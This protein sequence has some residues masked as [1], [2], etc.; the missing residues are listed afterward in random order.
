MANRRDNKLSLH[1]GKTESILFGSEIRL[2]RVNKFEVSC[3]GNIINPTHGITLD[4]NLSGDNIAK[5]VIK[6]VCSRLSFLYRQA[7]F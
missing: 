7:T 4:D 6:E 5:S 2:S 1:L 3:E